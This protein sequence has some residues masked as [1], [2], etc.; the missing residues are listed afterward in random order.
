MNDVL[1]LQLARHQSS[2]SFDVHSRLHCFRSGVSG[3]WAVSEHQ[4]NLPWR[5]D[6]RTIVDSAGIPVAVTLDYTSVRAQHDDGTSYNTS[7]YAG[8]I[9]AEAI[10]Q[11]VN[12]APHD[13][14]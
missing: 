1:L 5:F 3:E 11:A 10:C 2:S 7:E 8:I 6:G 12:G 14:A 13:T 4:L 9:R